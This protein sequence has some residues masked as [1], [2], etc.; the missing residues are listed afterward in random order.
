MS[1]YVRVTPVSYQSSLSVLIRYG[2]G[3][4]FSNFIPISAF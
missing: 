4:A 2:E 3:G 1:Q